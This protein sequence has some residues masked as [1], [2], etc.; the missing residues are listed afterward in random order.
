MKRLTLNNC[1]QLLPDASGLL[2]VDRHTFKALV[3][4]EE[5]HPKGVPER[6]LIAVL[7]TTELAMRKRI[8]RLVESGFVQ[9]K[10]THDGCLYTH[11]PNALE[12]HANG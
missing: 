8:K 2:D 7:G 4:L 1:R 3:A 12:G 11:N 6:S 9:S 5:G 10:T